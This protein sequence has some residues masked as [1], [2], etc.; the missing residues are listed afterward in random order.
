MKRA[1]RARRQKGWS[2]AEYL[3]IVLGLAVV[4]RGAQGVL[5]LMR[6]HHDEFL[7]TLMIPF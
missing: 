1:I 5:S 6:E 2:T 7:W 4:W 3:A